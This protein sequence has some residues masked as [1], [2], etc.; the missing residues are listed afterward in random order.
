MNGPA[1]VPV[2][3]MR[4]FTETAF[5]RLGTP[6]EDARLF[7]DVLLRSDLR[8]IESH[9]IGRL[10]VYVERYRKGMLS[11]VTTLDVVREGPTTAVLDGHHGVGPVIA[12]R[13]MRMAMEK[14][15]AFG[16]G[17]V[18]VRNSSHFGIAGY[19]P[20]M[21]VADGQV[22]LAVTNARPSVFPTFGS[23]PMLGTN[24]IAFGAP[25]D[26]PCPFLFDAATSAVPR[27]KL[28]V[29]SRAGQS[30]PEGWAA[31]SD[32]RPSTDTDAVLAGIDAGAYGLLPLGGWGEILGGHK[33]Y[34]LATM[35]EI[36]S[37]SLQAGPFLK[38]LASAG[39][40]GSA[41]KQAIGHFF[42]ALDVAAF[43]DLDAFRKRTGDIL[44]ALR[45]SK[46]L[47]GERIYTAGEKE[48][49]NEQRV[50]SRGIPVN[51]K[52]QQALAGVRDL[53]AIEEPRLP[54]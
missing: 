19:Y 21:A 24:P 10:H 11:P 8:G 25:T 20:L 31:T 49:E 43:E 34:G 23:E 5:C 53:L 51:R 7:A 15:R 48:W 9:G 3:T 14:A 44:R 52:L 36:L 37:A 29:A 26:E 32:G 12:V 35:V 2:A 46:P 27:G 50:L 47:G 38:D 13:A 22:G 18:A 33:G 45:S 42:F 6:V 28:E 40:D 4:A 30:M 41:R 17:A 1:L 39:A 16:L 54:F